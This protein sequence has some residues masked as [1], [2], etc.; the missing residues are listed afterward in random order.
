MTDYRQPG[1]GYAALTMVEPTPPDKP[2]SWNDHGEF[3]IVA[4]VC[5]PDRVFRMGAKAWLA[6]GGSGDGA[7]RFRWIALSRGP[8]EVEK[9]SPIWRF[10][11][12]RAAWVP[13]P[14]QDRITEFCGTREQAEDR[15]RFLEAKAEEWRS[16]K[17]NRAIGGPDPAGVR[18]ADREAA[19][20]WNR[21]GVPH[22]EIGGG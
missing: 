3:G 8:R 6:G 13:P 9:H 21:L 18:E 12:F 10:R 1:P 16:S 2:W 20:A 15:A 22:G 11:D 5:E 14:L 17:P 7:M 19:E 4:N